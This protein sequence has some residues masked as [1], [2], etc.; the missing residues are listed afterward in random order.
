MPSAIRSILPAPSL[1]L[2][3]MAC[4][5][6]PSARAQAPPLLRQFSVGRGSAPT[7]L[8]LDHGGNLYVS[9]QADRVELYSP[10]GTLLSSVGG[11]GSS[12]GQFNQPSGIG[13][14]PAGNLYVADVGNHRIQKFSAVGTFLAQWGSAGSGPGQFGAYISLAVD[15]SG[16][17]YVID[18]YNMRIQRFQADGTYLGQFDG[19][20]HFQDIKDIAFDA[21]GNGYVPDVGSHC[22][23]VLAPDGTYLR[24]W[25]AGFYDPGFLENPYQVGLDASG[26]LYA[27][28]FASEVKAFSSGGA[29]LSA[30][31]EPNGLNGAFNPLGVAIDA[32]GEVF[33]SDWN[34]G[35]ISVFGQIPTAA[36]PL[37]W[38]KLKALYR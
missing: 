3:L 7:Y 6:L 14:D 34:N 22:I 20:G 36:V 26:N 16:I 2:A 33:V 18:P 30:W 23:H 4:V 10:T 21:A 24:S 37:S 11:Q 17:V 31:T 29:F 13:V 28:D 27:P 19:S 38:G 9:E 8:A 1:A 32:H 25:C 35:V 5:F 12:P 15:A